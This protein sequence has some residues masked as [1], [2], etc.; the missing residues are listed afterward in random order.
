M[1]AG[2]AELLSEALRGRGA[3]PSCAAALLRYG[4]ET[5]LREGRQFAWQ[6]DEAERCFLVLGGRLSA[7]KHRAGAPPLALPAVGRGEWACLAEA[8]AS[9]PCQADYAAE[10]ESLC[11]AYSAYNL[12]ALRDNPGVERWIG[13]C[14]ARSSL[15]LHALVASGGP[16]QRIGAWLLSRRRVIGG[17]ENGAVS[18]TQAKIARCLGLSRETVNK[19]LA[20]FEKAGLLSTQ[21]GE[22]LIPDWDRLEEVLGEE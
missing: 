4:A 21:R 6:G 9:A 5:S 20:D 2:P 13:L 19:R 8:V 7:T 10:E 17:A 16:R 1:R 18:A 12:E 15:S 14:L 3:D 22:I 11:L